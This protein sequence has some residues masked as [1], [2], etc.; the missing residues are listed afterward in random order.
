[1][2]TIALA[3]C[4]KVG[5]LHKSHGI[6]GELVF[7]FEEEFLDSIEIA[8]TFF[9]KIDGLLV[10]FFIK[11]NGL[12]VKSGNSAYV[13]FKWINSGEKAR[14]FSGLEVYLKSINI[15]ETE[16]EFTPH[17]FKDFLIYNSDNLKIGFVINVNDYAGNIV[18]TID[19]KGNET[20]IPFNE[21]L[22]IKI[23]EDSKILQL[24]IPQGILEIDDN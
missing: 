5:Y 20:M 11:D 10:P 13:K 23:D 16:K 2:E 15:V 1:M 7:I 9:V 17:I 22:V 3:D 18:L 21:E 19:Y 24:K 6:H 14:E 12:K 8:S 4:Q